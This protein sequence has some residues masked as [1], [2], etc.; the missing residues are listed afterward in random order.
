MSA[1]NSLVAG[2]AQVD[3][4]PG[5]SQFL[6]G[7]PHVE[8]WS[9]GVHDP[10]LASALY[11]SDGG[12]EVVFAS[13]DIIYISK[14]MTQKVRER[15]ADSTGI[16]PA[17]VMVTATHT[18]SGPIT[19]KCLSN[20]ADPVVPEP[21]PVYVQQL[22]S[23]IVRAV[24]MAHENAQPAE[25]GLSH[26]DG[27]CVGTNRR[28]P[29]GPSIPS[30][31]VLTVQ[32]ANGKDILALMVVC[33]M[34]PTVLHEDSRLVSGDFPAMARQYLQ[35]EALC[36][37]CPV[38]FQTGACGNQSTRHVVRSNT[39]EEAE[40]LGGLL[41][42]EIEKAV[43]STPF[44]TDIQ[45]EVKQA[46]AELPLRFFP[47]PEEAESNLETVRRRLQPL[48]ELGAP[49][50]EVRTAECDVFGAEETL[51]LARASASG[52]VESVASTCLPAEIQIVRIG[53]WLIIGWPGEIF[54]E[55]A[56]AV[57]DRFPN[58]SI[59]TLANGEVQGYLVTEEAAQEGGYEAS[60]A[61]FQ[62]PDGGR[63]L[64]ESTLN[65]LAAFENTT[66]SSQS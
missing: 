66:K 57:R 31:P 19:V 36:S 8:R 63:I 9:E 1:T 28:E 64:V 11:L 49:K 15:I 18:H 22:E 37:S 52:R 27:S 34:H 20:E 53:D 35:N 60:N 5:D 62:S 24:R 32:S 17:N 55:F 21:D 29:A 39:F 51:V 23:G 7:Y 30:V 61:L 6:Y 48:Q 45:L 2:A 4:S 59:V 58:A 40:R 25:V 33:S 46:F 12:T 38:V 50:A 16:P 3:V 56:L 65:A 42:K 54:V 41:G 44:T 47:A 43:M 13:C 10:L 14:A 26:A